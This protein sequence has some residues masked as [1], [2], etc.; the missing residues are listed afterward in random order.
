MT[1]AEQTTN[2]DDAF[3][4]EPNDVLDAARQLATQL[5]E[6]T[7]EVGRLGER[8]LAMIVGAGEDARDRII[9]HDM[10][11]EA[12]RNPIVAGLRQ[13]THRGF[14]LGF[15]AI[16]VSVQAGSDLLDTVLRDRADDKKPASA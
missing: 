1:D 3:A 16:A 5:R 13:S 7:R 10:L 9:S 4:R 8:E 15:D 12:R 14:D 2:N 11:V 6:A